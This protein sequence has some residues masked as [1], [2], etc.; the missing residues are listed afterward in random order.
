MAMHAGVYLT[1][2][3][4]DDW[5]TRA[6][7]AQLAV[8]DS[9]WSLHAAAFVHGIVSA[10]PQTVALLIGLLRQWREWRWGQERR[11]PRAGRAGA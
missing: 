4:R 10:P 1:V 8:D 6:L 5:W 7:A 3:G 9:A 11:A 2:P